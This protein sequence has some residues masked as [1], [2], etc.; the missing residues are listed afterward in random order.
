MMTELIPWQLYAHW[1]EALEAE[2]KHV[3][4]DRQKKQQ[5]ERRKQ[6][7]TSALTPLEHRLNEDFQ[8][9]YRKFSTFYWKVR[10][11]DMDNNAHFRRAANALKA[12]LFCHS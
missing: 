6:P 9:H 10:S 2:G 8:T 4:D 5:E 1:A 11:N 3:Q 7:I 12:N